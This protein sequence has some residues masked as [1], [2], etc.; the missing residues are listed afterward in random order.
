MEARQIETLAHLGGALWSNPLEAIQASQDALAAAILL[1]LPNED[2]TFNRASKA[3]LERA[4]RIPSAI[5]AIALNHPFYRLFPEER[6][7]LI[8][9]HQARWS[10]KRISTILNESPEHLQEIAWNARVFMANSHIKTIT[11]KPLLHP[12]GSSKCSGSCPDFNPQ[13]PW[14]QKF[15]DDE[16]NHQER[17]FILERLKKCQGCQD[18]LTRCRE[19]YFAVEAAI[20]TYNNPDISQ[21]KKHLEETWKKSDHFIHPWKMTFKQTL[22]IYFKRREVQLALLLIAVLVFSMTQ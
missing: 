15:L 20:P 14:T 4:V 11:G 13:H 12:S 21:N 18:I 19:I 6:V 7:A 9:L 2:Q 8:T 5:D 22:Q 1:D 17:L 16:M 3:L 10:Y